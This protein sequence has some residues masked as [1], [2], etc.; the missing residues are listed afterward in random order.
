MMDAGRR[1]DVLDTA[2]RTTRAQLD[3]AR[4]A[5]RATES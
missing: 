4:R 2:L 3:A 1:P 5:R